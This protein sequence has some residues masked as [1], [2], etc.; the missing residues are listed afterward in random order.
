MEQNDSPY[1]LY[2]LPAGELPSDTEFYF[3]LPDID[4]VYTQHEPENAVLIEDPEQIPESARAWLIESIGD[5]TARFLQENENDLLQ[6]SKT[7]MERFQEELEKERKA[8][9]KRVK[10]KVRTATHG[11]R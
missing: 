6:G 2:A 10:V 8:N 7:F 9:A 1:K 4:L 3:L 5:I 11:K